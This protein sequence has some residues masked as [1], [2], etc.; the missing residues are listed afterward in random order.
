M[1]PKKTFYYTDPLKDDFSHNGFKKKRPLP[2][3]FKFYHSNLIWRFFGVVIYFVIAVPIL[4]LFAKLKTNYKIVGKKKLKKAHLGRKG[5]FIYGNHTSACDAFYAPLAIALPRR[6][7]TVCSHEAVSHPLIRWLEVMLAALPLP[8]YPEQTKP[9]C[10]AIERHINHG[11]VILIFPEAH[12]WPYCTRIRPFPDAS[13]FY[14]AKLG[15]PVVGICTTFEKRKFLRFLP[16]RSIIHVSKP[17]YPD[18]NLSLGERTHRLREQVYEFMVETSS[19]LDNVE[20][21]RYLPKKE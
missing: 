7:Y 15:S 8:Y 11:S 9:F 19:S 5:Y 4:W 16:P 20:Y 17:F 18:M 13:F 2:K 21:Y 3:K 14:P 6:T 1:L 10:E 12:I